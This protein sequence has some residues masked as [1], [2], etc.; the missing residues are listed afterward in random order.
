[1]FIN[2]LLFRLGKGMYGKILRV[3]FLYFLNTILGTAILFLSAVFTKMLLYKEE[4]FIFS[5]YRIVLLLMA[6]SL[7]VQFLLT[8]PRMRS[9]EKIGEDIKNNL[10]ISIL[11]KLF[12]LGPA[13]VTEQRTGELTSLVTFR[14]EWVK[15]YYTEYLPVAISSLINLIVILIFLFQ[16]DWIAAFVACV[17]ALV[18]II[19]PYFMSDLMKKEG[20][21]EWQV[22]D[23]YLSECL[24]SVQGVSVLKGFNADEEQMRKL[25]Q[26]GEKYRRIT[27]RHLRVTI[28]EGT[29]MDLFIRIGFVLPIIISVIRAEHHS[30]SY[31]L[32][33]Y[34]FYMSL[35]AFNPLLSLINA[36]HLGFNGMSAADKIGEMMKVKPRFPQYL[37]KDISDNYNELKESLEREYVLE[38][39]EDILFSEDVI[40]EQVSFSYEETEILHEISF[41]IKNGTMTA[42]VGA[43]GSG[44]STIAK[45]LGGFYLP[46]KGRILIGDY[47]L[48]KETVEK[49]RPY[50]GAVWQNPHLFFGSIRDNLKIGDV[51]AGYE[52]LEAVIEEVNLSD[53]IESLAKGMDTPVYELG[54]GFSGGERQRLLIA[55]CYLRNAPILIFDEATSSLDRKNEKEI[56][57]SFQKLRNGKTALVIAHRLSTIKEADYIIMIDNGRIEEMGTHEEL[58]QR[59]EKYRKLVTNQLMEEVYE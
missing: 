43:S 39:K 52:R 49:I 3:S 20:E 2:S 25:N 58:Q 15:K 48:N 40:F 55:R 16:L 59:S 53:L 14:S 23:A 22:H 35:A 30:L 34:I 10:R 26:D 41:R 24:D 4:S 46:S 31:K 1:M 5:D 33:I 11:N 7:I 12:L 51:T 13:Y 37:S 47:E 32:V 54:A 8:V 17:S 50:I 38:R 6:L 27:M 29:L 44:K 57:K 18:M 56:Q 36:W 21:K 19:L 9:M 28:S 42:L 45:L